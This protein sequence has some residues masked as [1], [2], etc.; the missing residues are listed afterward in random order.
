MRLMTPDETSPGFRSLPLGLPE[1]TH[2]LNEQ[3]RI[4]LLLNPRI[5]SGLCEIREASKQCSHVE[6]H[7]LESRR[8]DIDQINTRNIVL[9]PNPLQ[10]FR[11]GQSVVASTSHFHFSC[12]PIFP[13]CS[14][15]FMVHRGRP[16][17]LCPIEQ[18]RRVRAS[19]SEQ[20]KATTMACE[21][22]YLLMVG[23]TLFQGCHETPTT[24]SSCLGQRRY[25]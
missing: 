8:D 15:F 9:Y 25:F 24:A 3:L 7:K 18:S 14:V 4:L 11:N 10:P 6:S 1:R 20:R 21:K 2:E 5:D 22:S 19:I 12:H 23:Y 16:Y 17:L 13:L